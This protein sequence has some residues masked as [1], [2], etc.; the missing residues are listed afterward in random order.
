MTRHSHLHIAALL[1]AT[2]ALGPFA[3]DTYL[4]AFPE[5]A[6]DLESDTHAISLS[7]GVYVFCFALGQLL[8]GPLADQYG[9]PVIMLSGVG[10]FAGASIVLCSVDSYWQLM[11]TRVFQALGGGFASVC[12]GAIVRDRFS[13]RE[14]AKFFST[15]GLIMFL[16]PA[17]A[18]TLGSILLA[19][20]GWRS[21]F[22]FLSGYALLL[23]VCLKWGLFN[24]SVITNRPT[25][26]TL[27][28]TFIAKY[29]AVLKVRRAMPFLFVQVFVAGVLLSFVSHASFIYLEHFKV[30]TTLFSILFA[31]NVVLIVLMNLT[32]RKALTY[33]SPDRILRWAL[34]MQSAGAIAL[35]L[36]TML[37]PSL[38]LFVPAMVVTIGALGAIGPN[39]QACFMEFYAELSG[40]AAAVLGAGQFALGALITSLT[41]L[42]LPESL[43]YIILVQTLCALCA[44][45]IAWFWARMPAVA[46][47][48]SD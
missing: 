31:A 34:I 21:I 41:T 11:V 39:C 24:G 6:A 20:F 15:I 17:I 40:T 18:P 35:F 30:D 23:I 48:T 47:P 19:Q 46:D 12:V 43:F 38:T 45:T 9:R 27:S 16:A 7:I 3:L 32:S 33:Y 42:L 29:L 36:V 25:S 5:I 10:V 8:G 37:K 22:M 1:A 13:G 44:L 26:A 2:M 4:P 14:A 28:T